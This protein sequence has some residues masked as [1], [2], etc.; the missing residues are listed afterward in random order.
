MHI[1]IKVLICLVLILQGNNIFAKKLTSPSC[2][3]KWGIKIGRE[4]CINQPI[5]IFGCPNEVVSGSGC[6]VGIFWE[7]CRKNSSPNKSKNKFEPEI[8][9]FFLCKHLTGNRKD[10]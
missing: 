9:L 6:P 3:Q 5:L 1:F 4:F 10:V 7:P 8:G 2:Q